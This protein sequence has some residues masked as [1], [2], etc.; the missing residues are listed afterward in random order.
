MKEITYTR[1]RSELSQVLDEIRK[2]EIFT[3]TQRGKEPVTIGVIDEEKVDVV[4]SEDIKAMD[5]LIMHSNLT[6]GEIKALNSLISQ[7][8]LLPENIKSVSELVSHRN[9]TPEKVR[10]VNELISHNKM[11]PKHVKSVDELVSYSKLVSKNASAIS[12]LVSN[13]NLNLMTSNINKELAL[14]IKSSDFIESIKDFDIISEISESVSSN[15][16]SAFGKLISSQMMHDVYRALDDIN[17]NVSV[18]SIK[19]IQKN[20]DIVHELS[21][22]N[23]ISITD[24]IAE[25]RK[26]HAKTIKDLEDK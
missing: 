11:I 13:G 23:K 26:R 17:K 12:E 7:S 22:M 8:K 24:A 1:L 9:L 5:E 6:A 10:A 4:I 18:E 16:L 21:K 14:N 25:V 15:K 20:I 19:K 3:V 2:G